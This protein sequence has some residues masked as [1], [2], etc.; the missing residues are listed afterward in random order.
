MLKKLIQNK[1]VRNILIGAILGSFKNSKLGKF[2]LGKLK[3][4]S[5]LVARAGILI[6]TALGA[7]EYYYPELVLQ[8]G[9]EIVGILF[10]WLALELGFE[11]LKHEELVKFDPSKPIDLPEFGITLPK[12]PDNFRKISSDDSGENEPV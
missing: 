7:A 8:D 1:F 5:L 10:S 3:E 11:R 2:V 12:L 4:R 6:F 9:I